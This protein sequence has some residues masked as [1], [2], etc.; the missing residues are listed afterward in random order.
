M[1]AG[2]VLALALGTWA[3]HLGSSLRLDETL[4]RWVVQDGLADALDRGVRF[5]SQ[6]AYYTFVW[7]WTR[8]AGTSELA[9]RLPSL[10]FALGACFAM[11]RLGTRWTRDAE[12]G[13]LAMVVLVSTAL[14]FRESTDARPYM[15]GLLVLTE[16]AIAVDRWV[17][18]GRWRDAVW[19]G[20]LG[21]VLPHIHLFF[22]LALPALALHVALRSGGSAKPAQFWGIV[23]LL[24]VGGLAYLPVLQTLLTRSGDYSFAPE[25]GWGALFQVF[26]WVPPVAGLLGGLCVAGIGGRSLTDAAAGHQDDA[27]PRIGRNALLVLAVW[28]LLPLGLLFAVSTLSEGSIFLARYLIVSL[29]AVALLY[30]I[31]LRQIPSAPARLSALV[32]IGLAAWATQTRPVDDFRGAAIAV[33]RFVAGDAATPVLV[34]TGLIETQHEAWLR[35]PAAA[36]YL[37]APMH[38]YPLEGDVITLPRQFPG[39]EI[40]RSIVGPVLSAKRPF[41]VIEWSGNGARVLSGVRRE[42]EAA[43]YRSTLP[44]GFGNVRVALFRPTGPGATAR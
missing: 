7:L 18:Q 19:V 31:A 38:T 11:A 6:P 28:A 26:V 25:P 4:T 22:V 1:A 23:G 10:L 27:A 14:V 16:L 15:L 9:L 43:G 40:G 36:D 33:N 29:P 32:L 12:C 30:A 2:V 5:Q 39:P 41:A 21:A 17:E 13:V 34:A 37:Q 3:P 24:G 8:L 44:G 20:V 35:D 42:A